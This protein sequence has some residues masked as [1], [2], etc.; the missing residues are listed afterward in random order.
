MTPASQD[1]LEIRTSR[2]TI[3]HAANKRAWFLC[4]HI[5]AGYSTN[6]S[7]SAF[8]RAEEAVVDPVR[9][10]ADSIRVEAEQFDGPRTHEVARND[11]AIRS[12][13]RAIVGPAAEEADRARHELRR[14]E[15]QNV[16]ER[17]DVEA[18]G[19]GKGHGER[20]MHRRRP[21]QGP[22]FQSGARESHWTWCIGP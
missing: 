13:R 12:S 14:V 1:E 3:G 20:V 4:G 17:N 18:T 21:G 16:V 7:R 22:P 5:R 19:C 6:G 8:A 15:M 9:D 10:H 11:H 2:R